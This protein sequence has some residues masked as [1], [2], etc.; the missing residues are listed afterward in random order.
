[1]NFSLRSFRLEHEYGAKCAFRSL[2]FRK[3]CWF[4]S[5]DKQALDDLY[6]R[7]AHNIALDRDDRPVLFVES[8]WMLQMARE[9]F[10]KV[11]FFFTS[12]WEA[13]KN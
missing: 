4:H 2:D 6:A 9:G 7:K 3:A 1:M 12:E 5:D 10:P 8:D 11:Q 13:A